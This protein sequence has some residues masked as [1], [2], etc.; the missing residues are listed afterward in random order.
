M[1]SLSLM[2]AQGKRLTVDQALDHGNLLHQSLVVRE[3]VGIDLLEILAQDIVV[4]GEVASLVGSEVQDGAAN[5]EKVLLKI[6][7]ATILCVGGDLNIAVIVSQD[8]FELSVS[9]AGIL[10]VNFFQDI[11]VDKV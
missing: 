7:M 4:E 3:S 2:V 9:V 1:D 11:T 10:V 6:G 8:N 5:L